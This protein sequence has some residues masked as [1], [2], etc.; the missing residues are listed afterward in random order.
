M[1]KVS[2]KEDNHIEV[3]SFK[4]MF[5]IF[6]IFSFLGCLYEE[7]L[8]TAKTYLSDGTISFVTRRGLL[9]LE[10]S[11]IYG[12]GACLM[13]YL[14]SLKRY[15]KIDYFIIGAIV[16][17]AFE[18]L[19]SFL[20]EVFTQTTSWDYSNHFLNINGRT[21]IPFMIFWG[22]LCYILV[23]ILYPYI[24][25]KAKLFPVKLRNIIYYIL[26]IFISIDMVLS[27]S[28]CIRLGLRSRGYEPFTIYG[29]FLDRFYD[30]D[31]MS[32]SYTN[33][34]TRK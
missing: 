22:V 30:D 9:Y 33:M 29:E 12:W 15:K 17:G 18:Y 3:P 5:L 11:P 6:I 19:I 1:K 10:L 16:G 26:L 21:T 24:I 4:K 20:Q 28:A 31:R 13:V 2:N 8:F 23:D 25:A 34:K 32:K 27:F 14:L 7:V